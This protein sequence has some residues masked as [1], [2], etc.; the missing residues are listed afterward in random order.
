MKAL[1]ILGFSALALAAIAAT[2]VSTHKDAARPRPL[3]LPP[4]PPPSSSLP[5]LRLSGCAKYAAPSGSDRN[6]GTRRRPFATPQ[7]LADALHPGKVGCLGAGTYDGSDSEY[8]LRVNRG[9]RPN[10]PITIRSYPPRAAKLVGIVNVPHGSDHVRLSDLTIDGTGDENTI[11]VYAADVTIKGNDIT[12]ESRGRSCLILGNNSESEAAVRTIVRLN[13]FYECGSSDNGNEDHAIYA[14]N[15]DRARIVSNLF[16]ASAAYAIQFYPNARRSTFAHN[17]VDGGEHSVRG[18]IVFAGDS[19]YA[20]RGNEVERNVIAFTAT[21]AISS[22]WEATVGS[23]NL[24]RF[25]CVWI[26]RLDPID[27]DRGGFTAYRNVVS[28]PRFVDRG[29]RDYRLGRGS[30]C[31]RIV[32]FDTAA[33]IARRR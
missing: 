7:R 8:V 10:A 18:G 27:T 22:N 30:R 12:N 11:K 24:A 5:P 9:G 26:S 23:G 2:A 15:V 20:S 1:L 21:S 33:L 6:P 32:G 14:A 3:P 13:R 4:P 29:K 17:V 16:W 19:D 25:N 28:N 31:R